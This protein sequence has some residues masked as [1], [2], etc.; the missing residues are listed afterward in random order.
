MIIAALITESIVY[1]AAYALKAVFAGLLST[2]VNVAE[3]GD[4]VYNA[5]ISAKGPVATTKQVVKPS[6]LVALDAPESD[7]VYY[8]KLATKTYQA[9]VAYHNGGAG[10][11]QQTYAVAWDPTTKEALGLI[12]ANLIG[13]HSDT[14]GAAVG[15]IG[16]LGL[17][18]F[19]TVLEQR[20]LRRY[21]DNMVYLSSSAEA[22]FKT[23]EELAANELESSQVIKRVAELELE[24]KREAEQQERAREI[25]RMQGGA[26][27]EQRAAA[28]KKDVTG[29]VAVVT[30]DELA[31]V[32]TANAASALQGLASGVQVLGVDGKLG[33][34]KK[35]I[36]RIAAIALLGTSLT[37]P[38]PIGPLAAQL[39]G[40]ATPYNIL[41]GW[42]SFG[43]KGE[44][45][46]SSFSMMW[47]KKGFK[48]EIDKALPDS[49]AIDLSTKV[50]D[51]ILDDEITFEDWWYEFT[52][53]NCYDFNP[54][55]G[56]Y[57]HYQPNGD[58]YESGAQYDGT[59]PDA[60]DVVNYLKHGYDEGY[61]DYDGRSWAHPDY[62]DGKGVYAHDLALDT[63]TA[64]AKQIPDPKKLIDNL[65]FGI[66]S[67]MGF[68]KLSFDK[69]TQS[70]NVASVAGQC[71]VVDFD[72][73]YV[74][75]EVWNIYTGKSLSN[76]SAA[77]NDEV[78]QYLKAQGG[79]SSEIF[80][81]VY[82]LI[83]YIL[84]PNQFSGYGT[85]SVKLNKSGAK[86]LAAAVDSD[87][88]IAAFLK[89]AKAPKYVTAE[90][91]IDYRANYLNYMFNGRKNMGALIEL[92]RFWFFDDRDWYR[93]SGKNVEDYVTVISPMTAANVRTETDRILARFSDGNN[94]LAYRGVTLGES[95]KMGTFDFRLF[96]GYGRND[97][98]RM[99]VGA[100]AMGVHDLVLSVFNRSVLSTSAAMRTFVEDMGYTVTDTFV[101]SGL[102]EIKAGL[103]KAIATAELRKEQ[104]LA[105]IRVRTADMK[106]YRYTSVAAYKLILHAIEGVERVR[107]AKVDVLNNDARDAQ[108]LGI[109]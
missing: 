101:L 44:N 97:S 34:S 18:I 55:T 61:T 68:G 92:P 109:K 22:N 98:G 52:A 29:A 21:A 57:Y 79:T 17:D 41:D 86:A 91:V 60:G 50:I 38:G 35:S 88:R 71:R 94:Y 24:L 87:A 64:L 93:G 45:F 23:A 36:L 89:A 14:L 108:E 20:R 1:A 10:R 70:A 31:N 67:G 39:A 107:E 66:A 49:S 32:P 9:A 90:D 43:Q 83:D 105:Q 65:G 28:A 27:I 5:T 74:P 99:T 33:A 8:A 78:A 3:V 73:D 6:S 82:G 62:V 15:G 80:Q 104:E 100:P 85:Y 58:T 103:E 54:D 75:Y 16:G 56:M 7:G 102:D 13:P 106:D 63:V 48:Q 2:Q 37:T 76:V 95:E 96:G 42:G 81:A 46:H 19:A 11:P 47:I 59:Y 69:K 84:K 25:A 53:Q 51:A 12:N 26:E 4:T 40:A 72:P 30:A 77:V